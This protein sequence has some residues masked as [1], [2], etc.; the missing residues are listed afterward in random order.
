MKS[1]AADRICQIERWS[2]LVSTVN[3]QGLDITGPGLFRTPQL[4]ENVTQMP[5][6]VGELQFVAQASINVDRFHV[7]LASQFV[8][9]EIPFN[10]PQPGQRLRQIDRRIGFA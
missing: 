10:L 1:V 3:S 4:T 8:A 7:P 9:S 2:L 6:C 5:D